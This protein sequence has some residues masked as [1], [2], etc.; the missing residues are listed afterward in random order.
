MV[1]T[2]LGQATLD[3][4]RRNFGKRGFSFGHIEFEM[5]ADIF[6]RQLGL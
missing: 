1:V 5:Q 2:Y 6:N 4:D 3:E